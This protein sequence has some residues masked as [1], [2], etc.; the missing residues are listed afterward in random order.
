MHREAGIARPPMQ[1]TTEP[2]GS[3]SVTPTATPT[4]NVASESLKRSGF[5]APT[6]ATDLPA[7]APDASTNC[8]VS[9]IVSVPCVTTIRRSGARRIDMTKLSRSSVVTSVLSFLQTLSQRQPSI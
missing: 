1:T 9:I 5:L 4:L 2:G 3:T 8:A 6:N 7:A